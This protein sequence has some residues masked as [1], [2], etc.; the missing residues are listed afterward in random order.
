MLLPLDGGGEEVL[1]P[2]LAPGVLGGGLLEEPSF[3]FRAAGSCERTAPVARSTFS[4]DSQ[5][6]HWIT[7]TS[8]MRRLS[9]TRVVLVEGAALRPGPDAPPSHGAGRRASRGARAAPDDAEGAR[10]RGGS[11]A[12]PRGARRLG[13]RAE[14]PRRGGEIDLVAAEG[15]VVVFVEVKWRRDAS[16][17]APA[18]A[19][20]PG[21]RRKLLSAARAWLAENPAAG[22]RD[23]RF[24]VVAIEGETGRTD[25]IRGAFDAT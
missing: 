22:S 11:R 3:L 21:K 13:P 1:G 10:R 2:L 25:W 12:V 9:S 16:R 4:V 7:R 5:S 24:D 23:V 19:V 17:G 15:R 8:S 20:T 6:G 18:E 14:R